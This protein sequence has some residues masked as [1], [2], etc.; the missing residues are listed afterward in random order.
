MTQHLL[1]LI[2]F[3]PLVGALGLLFVPHH[4]EKVFKYTTLC[5]TFFQVVLAG[6]IYQAFE[7]GSGI[8]KGVNVEK[9]FQLIEKADW[10]SIDLGKLGKLSIDYF[11][12]IDGLSVMMVILAAIVLFIGVLASFRLTKK[13]KAYF[14]LYLLL[15]S[16]IMGCFVALDFFLFYL[17][18][19]FML[20]PMYFL[21]GL[22]G[23]KRSGYAAIKFFLYTLAGSVLILLA[24]IGLYISVIDPAETAVSIGLIS[25]ISEANPQIIAKVQEMLAGNQISSSNMVHTFNMVAMMD[26]ANFIPGS[27]L[28]T[29]G[30][31]VFFGLS[32]RLLAFLLLFIGF[33]VKLPVVPLHTWLPDAHVEAP[34]AISVVL[35]GVLLKVGGYGMLRTAYS[36]FPE[37]GFYFA[38][39][40]GLLAMIS[41]IYGAYNAL[42]QKD[43]KRL[44]AYSSVSH[45][46]FVLLGFAALTA[47]AINGALF[48]MFS[49]GLIS[50]ILFLITGVIY[51]RTA[52]RGIEHYSGLAGRMPYFTV[53]V[54]I[55][56]FASLG[57]PGFSGFIA[58]VLVF[59]GAFSSSIQFGILPKWMVILSTLGLILGAAYYLWTLQR[60]FF[61][62]FW[63]RE[64]A[65]KAK[66]TDLTSRE[67]LM[68][69][70]LVLLV[71]LFG[72]MPKFFL[73]PVGES[74]SR[75]VE[76]VQV[77][78]RDSLTLLIP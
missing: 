77:V 59:L 29:V 36:M 12:A 30:G 76:Y 23:G 9:E 68:L 70:P 51:D 69:V 38:W 40:V 37:G 65:W 35:A 50:A 66:L 55:A 62:K 31:S 47:E 27:I 71:I 78:G 57:L 2:I 10:I 74:V 54:V 1:S 20:L 18:F 48:Q 46:G 72:V 25:H 61:G 16:T 44:V 26:T 28:S 56:F 67:L 4:K 14:L 7:F 17:F 22:W 3:L 63:A 13:V 19:E 45:M 6:L 64:E 73:D 32:A 58:E 52:D 75:L 33:A 43:L 60:M 21:I 8:L 11:L 15:S 53:I 42:A 41:I 39:W 49:H 34:T 24:M 5:I